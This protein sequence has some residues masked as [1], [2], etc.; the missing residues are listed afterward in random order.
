[1]WAVSVDGLPVPKPDPKC[2]GTG[3]IHRL[4]IPQKAKPYWDW[5]ARIIKA[6]EVLREQAG[7][8]LDGPLGVD[9]TVTLPRPKSA[10]RTRL[11]PDVRVGDVDKIARA[12]LD[13]LTEA[14][15]W[16]DDSQVCALQ[17]NKAYP[18]SPTPDVLDDPGAIIRIWRLSNEIAF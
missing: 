18:G 16:G 11:W 1:M 3:G 8:T 5:R 17:A 12:V 9:V 2:F 6:G 4:S 13:A 14:G 10:P 15:L 7:G